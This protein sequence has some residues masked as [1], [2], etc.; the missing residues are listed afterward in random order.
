MGSPGLDS[1]PS[2]LQYISGDEALEI[3]QQIEK[4]LLPGKQVMW[5]GVPR[6]Y[7]Q[8]WADQRGLQTFTTAMGPL[9]D[10]KHPCCRRK[11]KTVSEWSDYVRG[12]SALFAA[13]LP[14]CNEVT[15]IL[16]QPPHQFRPD[17]NT[18]YQRFEQPILKGRNGGP[19][20]S[21]INVVHIMV[22]GAE[23]Y[24]YQIWPVDQTENW[25]SCFQLEDKRCSAN[26]R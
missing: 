18:T 20:M 11:D 12:A 8:E 23:D 5:S 13:F 9:M 2:L 15:V 22:K 19:A 7:V 25:K 16:R 1:S 26:K 14:K 3:A 4:V 6:E 17:G 24:S 21:R 10:K